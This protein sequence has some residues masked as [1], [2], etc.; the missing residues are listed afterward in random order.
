[1][2]AVVATPTVGADECVGCLHN[3]SK[4]LRRSSPGCSCR[5]AELLLPALVRLVLAA[6]Y[7]AA[8][9]LASNC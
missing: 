6:D 4:V 5:L 7:I 1:M 2:A 3:Y 9:Q 8:V